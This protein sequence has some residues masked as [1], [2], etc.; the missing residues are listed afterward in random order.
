MR[1]SLYEVWEKVCDEKYVWGV[2]RSLRGREE[3]V[4]DVWGLGSRGKDLQV[5]NRVRSLCKE[6]L[7]C[8]DFFDERFHSWLSLQIIA[9]LCEI[10]GPELLLFCGN[11]THWKSTY[12]RV[13]STCTYI[14]IYTYKYI[15]VCVH[16]HI[17]I[18]IHT[19]IYIYILINIHI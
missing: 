2:R 10:Y 3:G 13:Y 6:K 8:R 11:T 7:V 19:H 15:Y 14:Y 18:Y 5:R 9:I 1:R 17:Y 4:K 12:M 16:M